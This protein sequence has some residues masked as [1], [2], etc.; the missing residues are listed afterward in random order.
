MEPLLLQLM[1]VYFG[2]YYLFHVKVGSGYRL[3]ATFIN[4]VINFAAYL[5]STAAASVDADR[6]V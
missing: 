5:Q 2:P 4:F 6:P 3:T 1:V